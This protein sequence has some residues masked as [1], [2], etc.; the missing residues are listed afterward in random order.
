MPDDG[1]TNDT[2]ASTYTYLLYV[3]SETAG[4]GI[5][6]NL[7]VVKGGD[8]TPTPLWIGDT[9]I[10]YVGLTTSLSSQGNLSAAGG[11]SIDWNSTY[12]TVAN[13]SSTNW[14]VSTLSGS[15]DV[16][17]DESLI[18]GDNVF[19]KYTYASPGIGS[20]KN[21]PISI[22]ELYNVDSSNNAGSP[23]NGQCLAW[24]SSSSYWTASSINVALNINDLQ[25]VSTSSATERDVLM[26][27][28]GGTW[29]PGTINLD[30]ISDVSSE[31]SA[32]SNSDFLYY[33]DSWGLT[34]I[35]SSKWDSTYTTLNSLSDTIKNNE[36]LL[37]YY[38]NWD[39]AY[40]DMTLN[41]ANWDS[42]YT[43]VDD[44]SANWD[45]T[46][47]TVDSNS[48]KWEVAYSW[49]D[50]AS[51]NY[52]SN[53]SS[54]SDLSDV[55]S[56]FITDYIL[57]YNGSN[58]VPVAHSVDTTVNS[59]SANWDNTYTDVSSNSANWDSTHTTVYDNSASWSS[60]LTDLSSEYLNSLSDVNT[61]PSSDYVVLR[62]DNG[63]SQWIDDNIPL[64]SISDVDSTGAE[65]P[66]DGQLLG[67]DSTNSYWTP[68]SVSIPQELSDLSDID[69]TLSPNEWD[70]LVNKY[71]GSSYE[72][73]TSA[74]NTD[75]W[76]STYTTVSSNSGNWDS[77]YT[78]VSSNSGNW[79]S[80]YTTVS[81]NSSNW[82]STY[83]T[84]Y[85]NSGSWSGGGSDST[86][87]TVSNNSA[88]WNS[89]YTTV[90]GNSANWETAYG[91]DDHST[92]GYLTSYTEN[93][94]IF[95]A[96][97]AYNIT[98]SH[99]SNWDTAYGWGDHDGLYLTDL[100]S[101]YLGSLSDVNISSET[102]LQVL[103]WDS[104]N[105]QWIN[106][107][108]PLYSLSD[109][110]S[111]GTNPDDGQLLGWDSTNSYWTPSSVSIPGQLSDLSDID[112]A[113]SPSEWDILVNRY[114]GMS[115]EW[116]ASAINTSNWGSTH[117]TVY[118]NSGSWGTGGSSLTIQDEGSDVGTAATTLN[119]VGA[120]VVA[121]GDYGTKTITING[122]SSTTLDDITDVS[123]SGVTNGQV[124]KYNG[125]SWEPADDNAGSGGSGTGYWS[126]D[127]S[128]E[129][130]YY[131]AA[132]VGISDD[133][134]IDENMF[135]TLSVRASGFGDTS[136]ATYSSTTPISSYA[137]TVNG[138][139][140][141]TDDYIEQ[142]IA[143]RV[144]TQ[145]YVAGGTTQQLVT[146]ATPG[147]TVTTT[148]LND[149]QKLSAHHEPSDSYIRSSGTDV[150]HYGASHVIFDSTSNG[151]TMVVGAPGYTHTGGG[152]ERGVVFV[153]TYNTTDGKF[154]FLQSLYGQAAD[155]SAINTSNTFFGGSW[156]SSTASIGSV[157][158]E[159]DIPGA[160]AA[161]GDTIVIGAPGDNESGTNNDGSIFIYEYSGSTW[162]QV[163]AYYG[164]ES[165]D[166]ST[167][168]SYKY[169][170]G[171]GI[172]GDHLIVGAPGGAQAS[173]HRGGVVYFYTRS[174][175][176]W[177]S[178]GSGHTNY[179]EN[180]DII[181][182]GS[183]GNSE[184]FGAAVA[185]GDLDGT[186]IAFAGDPRK[187]SGD[188]GRVAVFTYESSSWSL[189]GVLD[190][191]IDSGLISSPTIVENDFYGFGA[192]ISYD[193]N[194][195]RLAIGAPFV[196]VE[197]DPDD[198]EYAGIV[199][200]YDVSSTGVDII[201]VLGDDTGVQHTTSKKGAYYGA[202]VSLSG[203]YLLVGAPGDD[204]EQGW[205][206]GQEMGGA[207]LYTL[208]SVN[209][210]TT[211]PQELYYSDTSSR[212]NRF[213]ILSGYM[214]GK[215]DDEGTDGVGGSAIASGDRFGQSV[216]LYNNHLSVG[217]RN[218]VV[219]SQNDAGSVYHY[220]I[221][222]T[223]TTT[224]GTDA[225][226]ETVTTGGD[227]L[228]GFHT[229]GAAITHE[230]YDRHSQGYLHIKTRRED[231]TTANLSSTITLDASGN[232]G[233]NCYPDASDS[234][235]PW[236]EI[237]GALVLDELS[238]DPPT[239][240]SG[241]VIIWYDGT[242]V[243]WKNDS[244]TGNL[245]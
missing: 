191:P 130:I 150:D 98:S 22:E 107:N 31:A 16:E 168:Y 4:G 139:T 155:G 119:F 192:A 94:P 117:T 79:D 225:V 118:N 138:V 87:T 162:S 99:I 65:T 126:Q 134:Y 142:G 201:T 196:E 213:S 60:A 109:V 204:L 157:S 232:V 13:N 210:S 212:Y 24:D 193:S 245:N 48:S 156:K 238:S 216:Q 220:T 151:T 91:W 11:N 143:F 182:A 114:N 122:G 28:G 53:S 187:A 180:S 174:G 237:D 20:W 239:P 176:T 17:I 64:Y 147:T 241:K 200:V 104:G 57:K 188:T 58:W 110:N 27:E 161:E 69:S 203:A 184:R 144:G 72:W 10:P 93:D 242:N 106:D 222:V 100:S 75:K 89:T 135:G 88:N 172:Y 3:S 44:N 80:T 1:L 233:F 67:W 103:R 190:N 77:T 137:L 173:D 177:P 123:T 228:S 243:K 78:T 49:N 221:D 219:N 160:I 54:I 50:H 189:S 124:L 128:T 71:N 148:T 153:Y 112:S 159:G 133:E 82:D 113:L 235:N 2:V 166:G 101:E 14:N 61:S 68:S 226:Y 158:V 208:S 218:D 41:S 84:V 127:S 46:Y 205:A 164:M 140:S 229:P 52:L 37:S 197:E 223:S 45:K 121:T 19:L 59:N 66:D 92:Q 23:V 178:D 38:V 202:S 175:G 217:C 171:V 51:Y 167:G 96:S 149:N 26:Y 8:G 43:T 131:S 9:T 145:Q 181:A 5:D 186:P 30:D 42:T 73:T 195:K 206:S 108:V 227:S 152:N 76:G 35:N 132:K 115:Y 231:T 90:S 83:T 111:M 70:I 74:I 39:A 40:T 207:Y 86:T 230:K 141:N 55:G 211:L 120:G 116:T 170:N 36:S 62:W 198:H 136:R 95:T 146:P 199:S 209:A 236:V 163:R 240:T 194:H 169:G 21:V 179:F 102:D 29:G 81:S 183:T 25:D 165:Y 129:N 185:I 32:P 105:S 56:G 125:S 15:T 234:N 215:E 33:T 34:S 214:S 6:S 63:N 12:T 7:K 97:D 18:S 85:N 224:G 47:T 244:S 154:E